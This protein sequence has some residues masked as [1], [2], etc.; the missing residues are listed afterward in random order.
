LGGFTLLTGFLVL[1]TQRVKS[2]LG[3]EGMI[4]E[5]GEVRQRIGG[6]DQRGKVFVHGEYWNAFADQAI[7][8]N[9]RVEI[10][11]I[12]GISLTVR[13]IKPAHGATA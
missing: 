4:G 10:V 1:R 7:E 9:E 2:G 5:T 12:D 3:R 8:A 11:D 6:G 13:R